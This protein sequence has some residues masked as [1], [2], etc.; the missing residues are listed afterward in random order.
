MYGATS[1]DQVHGWVALPSGALPSLASWAGTG[2]GTT[3]GDPVM[4]LAIFFSVKILKVDHLSA[5]VENVGHSEDVE[6]FITQFLLGMD[7][8]NRKCLELGNR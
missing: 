1:L 3:L 5:R 6:G 4:I 7:P 2:G 8:W